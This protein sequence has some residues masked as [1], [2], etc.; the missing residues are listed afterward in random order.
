MTAHLVSSIDTQDFGAETV[1][2]ADLNNDGAHELLFVQSDPC[3]RDIACLTATDLFGR[4]L[5]QTGAA[6]SRENAGIYSDLAAQVYDWDGDGRNEVLWVEQSIYAESIVWDYA[7]AKHIGVPTS[8]RGELRG[9]KGWALEGARRYED[10]AI[11]HVLDGLTGAEKG[12][13]RLPAPADDCIVFANLT[14]GPRRNDLVVKDRYWNM[15]GVAHD[16]TVLW[17]WPGNA[18]HYPA[19][20]DV[21]GDGLDE[22]FIGFY[23][24]DHDGSVLWELDGPKSHQDVSCVVRA[25]GETRLVFS[26]GEGDGLRGGVRCLGVDGRVLW[27]HPL[28]HA[29]QVIPGRFVPELGPL[30]FAVVDLG[31][32]AANARV[33][34]AF[35]MLD[36]DGTE[37]WRQPIPQ[38]G[39]P[40]LKRID[41]L[42]G[43]APGDAPDCLVAFGLAPAQPAS[44]LDGRGHM[45]AELPFVRAGGSMAG[46]CS[47]VTPANVWGDVRE[48]ALLTAREGLNIYTN[49]DLLALPDLYNAT[50]YSGH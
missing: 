8:R 36:W 22:V 27:Q 5:W 50:A 29:Q 10:D 19:V 43:G 18:G 9:H 34:A 7:Q 4:V 42:G 25:G 23:L 11:L 15:W 2:I 35:L 37:V 28:G 49:S 44:I 30:Q 17:H 41:W 12:T 16:G 1:R 38:G 33:D 13:L 48:E 24:I 14:G 45:L 20:A 3:T 21:D 39:G 46:S 47:Y 31:E 40:G 6:P 32:P 26:H